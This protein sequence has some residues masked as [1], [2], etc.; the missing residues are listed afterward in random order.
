MRKLFIL[1]IFTSLC[2]F[3][4]HAQEL[5]CN[6]SVN[7]DKIKS[8]NKQIATSLQKAIADFLNNR[9]WTDLQFKANEKI[10]CSFLVTINTQTDEKTFTA[11]LQVQARRPVYNSSYYTSLINFK[12]ENFNFEY[13]EMSPLEY[14]DG[15]Y[16][17]NLTAVL[18]YYA[19]VIIGYDSDSFSKFGG[20][21]YFEK[22][23]SIVNLAQGESDK[24]WKAFVDDR[25]RYALINNLL[26]ENLRKFR[27]FYYDYHRLGLDEMNS[28]VAKGSAKIASSIQYLREVNRAR[29]SCVALTSF[30]EAKRD[31]IVNVFSNAPATEKNDV[32]NLLMD[33]D[34]SQ[35]AKY[36]PILKSNTN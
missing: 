10:E 26:D 19:Y 23:E 35:S 9:K 17:S 29:A 15:S 11:T 20:T 16:S 13:I 30:L 8:N 12:D 32:Y 14:T 24:G 1:F 36:E 18:A 4:L 27:E 21:P 6:V 31:E 33:I 5:T 3:G 28:D 25:N 7:S 22:A 34:P 2:L